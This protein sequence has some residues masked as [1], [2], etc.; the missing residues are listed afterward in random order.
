M[1][2]GFRSRRLRCALLGCTAFVAPAMA[3]AQAPDARPRLDR[4]VAGG[5][6]VQQDAARTQVTQ[7]AQ[8]GIVDW[9]S[10]DVGRDHEVRF[11]QPSAQSITLNRVTGPDP[12]TIAGRITANGQVAIVNQSGVVFSQG[13]QV[14]AAGLI[15]SAAGITNQNFLD[16]RMVFDQAPRPGARVENNGTI[17]VREAGLAALVAPQVAN[18]GTVTA[19][20]GRVALAG[21]ETHVVDLH[22]DGLLAI[23]VTGPVRHAGSGPV[24]SNTGTLD[25]SGGTVQLTAAAVDGLVQDL[26]RGGGRISAGTDPVSGR[27]GRVV[28]AGTGGALRIEGDVTATASVPGQRGGTV[29]AVADRVW[30]AGGARVD[31]SGPAAGGRVGL[32]TTLPGAQAPRLARR[33]GTAPGSTVRADSTAR[34]PGGTVLVNS[35]DHTAHGGTVSARGGPQ[36]GDGGFV[37][38]SGQAGLSV[39]GT[40]DVGAH[41]GRHGTVLFDPLDLRIV[42]PEDDFTSVTLENGVLGRDAPPQMAFLSTTQIARAGANVRVETQRDLFVNAPLADTLPATTLSL[43]AGRNL[44][45]NQPIRNFNGLTLRAESGDIRL[46]AGL[47][48]NGVTVLQAGGS[49]LMPA[50]RTLPGAGAAQRVSAGID[51]LSLQAQAGGNILFEAR[52]PGAPSASFE[53][54]FASREATLAAGVDWR[55]GSSIPGSVASLDVGMRITAGGPLTLSAQ[56]SVTTRSDLRT[57]GDALSLE[58]ATGDVT[59]QSTTLIDTNE[60]EGSRIGTATFR[61]GRDIFLLGG[62]GN[63]GLFGPARFEA[64]RD[65]L[66]ER[67]LTSGPLRATAGRNLA[68]QGA[69]SIQDPSETLLAAG[70][71]TA[72]VVTGAAGALA[73]D[74]PVTMAGPLRLQAGTGGIQQAEPVSTPVLQVA[75]PGNANLGRD[76]LA[77]EASPNRIGTLASSSVGGNLLLATEGRAA[78]PALVAAGAQP[79]ALEGTTQVGGVLTLRPGTGVAQGAANLL[80][81]GTLDV[82][83]TGAV[84]LDGR[85]EIRAVQRLVGGPELR[86]RNGPDLVINGEARSGGSL[87]LASEAGNLTVNGSVTAPGAISL[88]AGGNLVLGP[89][90]SVSGAGRGGIELLASVLGQTVNTGGAGSLTIEGRVDGSSASEVRLGAGLGGVVQGGAPISAAELAVLAGGNAVLAPTTPNAIGRLTGADVG[91]TFS[92]DA[93]ALGGA[94]LSGGAIRASAVEIRTAAPLVLSEGSIVAPLRIS[95][96]VGGLTL[97]GGAELRAP[98]VEVTPFRPSAVALQVPVGTASEAPFR[99][100]AATLNAITA[101]TLRIGEAAFRGASTVTADGIRLA[102]PLSRN[103]TLELRSLA[104]V[105]QSPGAT[106]SLGALGVRAAGTVSLTEAGNAVGRL[107]SSEA[108]GGFAL[109]STSPVLDLPAGQMLRAGG[110]LVLQVPSGALTVNGTAMGDTVRLLAGGSLSVNGLS[111]IAQTGNLTLEGAQVSVNG[112]LSA[113]GNIIVVARDA[114]DLSGRTAAPGRTL[115]IAAPQV[116]FTALDARGTAVLLQ[117]GSN[118]TASGSLDAGGLTVAGGSRADLTGS[119]NGTAGGA[120]ASATRRTNAAGVPLADPPPGAAAFTFNGCIMASATCTVPE[121][122]E[123]GQPAPLDPPQDLL[124]LIPLPLAGDPVAVLGTL[125]PAELATAAQRLRQPSPNLGFRA[126]QDRSAEEEFA[127]PDVRREDF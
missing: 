122:P 71:N 45:V 87:R 48:D 66:L 50:S 79:L 34:G 24:V 125:D 20:H 21:A 33:T 38:V 94:A 35:Q 80:R 8:R 105:V 95:L 126:A 112:L 51:A 61:A 116:R 2:P 19:R 92:L 57:F 127:P 40:I 41:A 110:A 43:I 93:T 88:R 14:E 44:E 73:I 107:L 98:L 109:T 22:G 26:V 47:F 101:D 78:S 56:G 9:R 100:G 103:G 82:E 29:E 108:G 76:G 4:V 63:D 124:V 74:A 37:E 46:H 67:S 23:E 27:T 30:V 52:L 42:S 25:A 85:N 15:V 55:T 97:N 96:R 90:G 5:I 58:A 81:V 120:A 114:A 65:I 113:G 17:T 62:S 104:D 12:S 18:R 99:L 117:L 13:S 89:S 70:T 59:V 123:E 54:I 10:F 32:G 75:T 39:P 121:V 36:G 77:S 6:A 11:A 72:G 28:L 102:A 53:T 115:S 119:V 7:Q 1:E 16:G 68:V 84:T 111:A 91:G 118:G 31:A 86:L 49:I 3:L 69:I 83:T 60:P 106:M 64:G